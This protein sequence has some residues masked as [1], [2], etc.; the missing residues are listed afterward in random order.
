[1]F[2]NQ[3][4]STELFADFESKPYFEG[5]PMSAH[6]ESS[7]SKEDSTSELNDEMRMC[8]VNPLDAKLFFAKLLYAPD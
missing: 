7:S 5:F 4:F 8:S 1:M 3:E 6:A 2:E